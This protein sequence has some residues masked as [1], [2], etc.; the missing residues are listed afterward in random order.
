MMYICHVGASP[1]FY[2]LIAIRSSFLELVTAGNTMNDIYKVR[3]TI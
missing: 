1:S 2:N 3:Q